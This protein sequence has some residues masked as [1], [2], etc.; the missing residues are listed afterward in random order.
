[1]AG[2]NRSYW[3]IGFRQLNPVILSA[4][5]RSRFT[6]PEDNYLLALTSPSHVWATIVII[7]KG[8][9]IYLSVQQGS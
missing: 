4:R 6:C 9:P 2:F 8:V 7:K 5:C 1:M 3:E